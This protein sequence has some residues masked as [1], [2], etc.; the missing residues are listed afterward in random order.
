M[1]ALPVPNS[2]PGAHVSSQPLE[3]PMCSRILIAES[4]PLHAA[5]TD[6]A[7]HAVRRIPHCCCAARPAQSN[8]VQS[9]TEET[10]G[11]TNPSCTRWGRGAEFGWQELRTRCA[12]RGCQRDVRNTE[13]RV[14]GQ[15]RRS[16]R[17][18]REAR[19]PC[20]SLAALCGPHNGAAGAAGICA[21]HACCESPW[22]NLSTGTRA[23]RGILRTLS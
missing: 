5:P 12:E 21:R 1:P 11:K 6:Q 9:A 23:Q 7:R 20:V 14:L 8:Y 18:A 19:V 17:H 16:R 2:Q 4:A 3:W 10:S 13:T 15:G 22:R